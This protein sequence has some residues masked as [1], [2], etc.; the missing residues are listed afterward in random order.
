[1]YHQTLEINCWRSHHCVEPALT[2]HASH[3]WWSLT[4]AAHAHAA[5]HVHAS[6]HAHAAH[7]THAT[8]VEALAW[9]KH[10]VETDAESSEPNGLLGL[11]L[12]LLFFLLLTVLSLLL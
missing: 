12:G 11:L 6:A 9:W 7:A 1:M 10:V 4:E 5:A 3:R 8:G 2:A